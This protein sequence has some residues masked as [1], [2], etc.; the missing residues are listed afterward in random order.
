MMKVEHPPLSLQPRLRIPLFRKA[1][2][3]CAWAAVVRWLHWPRA[4]ARR[5]PTACAGMDDE[6]GRELASGVYLY[7]VTA[8]DF[9][10]SKKMVLLK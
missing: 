3:C 6:N 2:A 8:G 10:G 7:R 9:V 4:T 1:L 5:A